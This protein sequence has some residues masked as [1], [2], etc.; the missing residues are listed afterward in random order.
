MEQ[1]TVQTTEAND[2]EISPEI[3][4]D[5]INSLQ[6]TQKDKTDIPEKNAKTPEICQKTPMQEEP[7]NTPGEQ[8]ISLPNPNSNYSDSD[9]YYKTIERKSF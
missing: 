3:H 5:E 1:A 9:R 2:K 4:H 8:Y 6:I 7:I